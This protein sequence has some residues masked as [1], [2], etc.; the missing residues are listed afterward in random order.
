MPTPRSGV[1]GVFYKGMA[2]VAGGECRERK[3]YP[4]MEGYDV[5]SGRWSKLAPLPA[6]RH[7]FGGAV[8]GENLYFAGGAVECGGG[9]RTDEL[10]LFTL[11]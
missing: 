10:L 4:E 9:Q 7:G 1:A 2:V 3:T 5:K 6:G 11:P 8:V